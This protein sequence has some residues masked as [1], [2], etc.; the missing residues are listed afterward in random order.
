MNRFFVRL[1]L[2]CALAS[3]LLLPAALPC[4]SAQA[5]VITDNVVV[6]IDFI[7]TACDGQTVIISGESRV[8]VHSVTSDSGQTTFRTHIQ[9]HLS[10]E[11]P[12]GTRYTANETVNGT[13]TSGTGSATTFTSIGQLHLISSGSDDNLTVRTTIHTTINANGQVTSTNF[14]F[15]TECNG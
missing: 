15:T 7:A 6:P 10:G 3:M 9:F 13:E 4:V 8:I 14:E 11:A 2:V 1:S 12:D 5:L